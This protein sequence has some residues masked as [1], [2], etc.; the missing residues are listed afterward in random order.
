MGDGVSI[1]GDKK[2]EKIWLCTA[3]HCSAVAKIRCNLCCHLLTDTSGLTL[4]ILEVFQINISKK[5]CHYVTLHCMKPQAETILLLRD[6]IIKNIVSFRT[7]SH[8]KQKVKENF[9]HNKKILY[10]FKVSN[11]Y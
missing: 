4:K 6:R 10:G 5:K 1:F 7:K 3:L 9:D 2:W 11:C 8:I